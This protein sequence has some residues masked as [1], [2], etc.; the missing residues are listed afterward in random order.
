M[1][2]KITENVEIHQTLPDIPNLTSEELKKEWDKGSKIIKQYF[3]EL[4]DSLN[5]AK[6]EEL[7]E[8]NIITA[9]LSSQLYAISERD[10]II[11]L[12]ASN[13]LGDK[14]SLEN[15]A[16]K[17]GKGVSKVLISAV[18]FYQDYD[19][20]IEYL[21]PKIMI[22]G[23]ESIKTIASR[24][25]DTTKFQSVAFP[26]VMIEVKEGDLITLSSGEVNP[27]DQC[28]IRG[29]DKGALC[30]YMTVEVVE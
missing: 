17:I 4:I 29:Y 24:S 26:P 30:T 16:I 14:L 19:S 27:V 2:K 1:L 15:N 13:V 20:E 9:Y 23:I 28:N 6:V 3:N 12:D 25:Y 7:K 5:N 22:N 18:I 10:Q 21:Y 8:K 11:S